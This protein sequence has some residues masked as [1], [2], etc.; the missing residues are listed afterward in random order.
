MSFRAWVTV[1]TLVL[2]AVVVFFGWPEI[3]KAF[4]LLGQTNG[5]ILALLIPVQILSYYATGG[6]I[7]S[8]LKSNGKK[9]DIS[10]WQMSRISLELNF[11][12]HIVPSGGAAGFSYLGWVLNRHG[13]SPGRSTMSQVVRFVLT[14]ATFLLMLIASVIILTLDHHINA[15]IILLSIGLAVVSIGGSLAVIYIISAKRHLVR[16]SA[17]LTRISNRAISFVTAGRK[18][19]V[20][21]DGVIEHF[22]TDM[23]EDY[24][25]IKKDARILFVPFLW[26]LVANVFDVLLLFIAFWALG[27]PVN[28]AILVVA[29]GLS[30][31]ASV[32]SITPG[33]AGVYEAVFI[34]FLATAGVPA[35]LAI[36][37]TLLARVA[38]LLGT[39]LFGYFFY[40]MTI[41]K[42]GKHTS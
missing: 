4:G 20:V 22:F 1:I 32:F 42:Y 41:N 9:L 13:V 38:L 3:V 10:H 14:F 17:W 7:F 29:F 33:G 23:H 35:D 30:S 21:A 36:A 28:P 34:A 19:D 6:M 11:V 40:Q 8:Y 25:V 2:L 5:W 27:A 12:N 24:L 31:I 18:K 26:A 39:V 16:F 15:T 37:G